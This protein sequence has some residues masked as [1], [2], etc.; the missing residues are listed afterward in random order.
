MTDQMNKKK[1]M[2]D[3]TKEH[4]QKLLSQQGMPSYTNK[5]QPRIDK[6]QQDLTQMGE[7]D[8]DPDADAAYQGYRNQY[9]RQAQLAN[10]NAQATAAA[11]TGGYSSS[12]G[13]QAGQ[14]AYDA[15][16][17]GLDDVLDGLMSQNRSEYNAKKNGYQ[18]ELN[19]LQTEQSR[20]YQNYQQNLANWQNQQNYKQQQAD[21]EQQK[22][23]QKSSSFWGGLV[24]VGLML[25]SILPYFL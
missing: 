3:Y 10:R 6:V 24:N 9:S 22:K 5:Y 1:E 19:A 4:I 14:S 18:Q 21:K 11:R 7:F 13:V 25:A 20:E 12:Y 2:A 17:S 16:M 23:E 15:T 8:Y